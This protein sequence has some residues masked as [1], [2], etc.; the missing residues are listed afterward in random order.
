VALLAWDDSD[1]AAWAIRRAASILPDP[2]RALVVF[3]HA[4]SEISGG[5][6]TATGTARTPAI[7]SE[8]AD[9]VLE[10]GIQ[11]ARDAGFDAKGLRIPSK[12]TAAEAITQAADA[13]DAKVIVLGQQQRSAIGR[14]VLGSVAR[15]VIDN[16]DRPAVVVGTGTWPSGTTAPDAG[17]GPV[18]LCW[19]GSPGAARAIQDARAILGEDRRAIVLFVHVP[20]EEAKGILG[21]L[22][23]PDA[24]IMG[25]ADAEVLMEAGMRAAR[26]VGFDAGEALIPATARTAEIIRQVA[27]EHDAPLIAMGQRQRSALGTLLLGS[28]AREVL[29]ADHRPVLLTGPGGS[30]PYP[31][32]G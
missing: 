31:S 24:P 14:L 28:V 21:G 11:V 32:S 5:L 19:D 6:L 26:A 1:S 3:V 22:S 8:A 17:T 13:E 20:V 10:R 27:D 9:E 12:G 16:H 15:D 30:G 4:S 2:R 29:T 25:S 7:S 23:G 18:I